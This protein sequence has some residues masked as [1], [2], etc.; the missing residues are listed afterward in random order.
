VTEWFKNLKKWQK[1]GL[2]GCAVGLLFACLLMLTVILDLD[3]AWERIL[4]KWIT[5]LHASLHVIFVLFMR[6]P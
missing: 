6:L 4:W 2:I 3:S 1:R 5:D